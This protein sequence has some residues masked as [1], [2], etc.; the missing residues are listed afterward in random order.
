VKV[1]HVEARR[2][3]HDQPHAGAGVAA[4]DHVGRLLEAALALDRQRPFLASRSTRAP[5][6]L[7]AAAVRQHV[8]AFQQALDL[9]VTAAPGRRGSARGGRWTC[10]RGRARRSLCRGPPPGGSSR[11]RKPPSCMI[12]IAGGSLVMAGF[13]GVC[14]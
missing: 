6:L 2:R 4:V 12:E 8:V 3:P 7:M 10:R 14:F 9:V 13:A 11:V 1:A 5:K